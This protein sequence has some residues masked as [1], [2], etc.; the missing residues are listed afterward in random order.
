MPK[1]HCAHSLVLMITAVVSATSPCTG[2]SSELSLADCRSWQAFYDG[3]G[4]AHWT[5]D[6]VPSNARA[7]PCRAGEYYNIECDG[8]HITHVDLLEV[9]VTGALSDAVDALGGMQ[10]LAVLELYGN[11]LNGTIP[12]AIAKFTDLWYLDLERNRLTGTIP[13]ALGRL[14]KLNTTYLACNELSGTVPNLP[15]KQYAG[16][17]VLSSKDF[18]MA[19]GCGPG[20][21]GPMRLACP[22]PVNAADCKWTSGQGGEGLDKCVQS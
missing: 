8:G 10:K 7:D 21:Y 19:R 12:A 18:D 6:E 2:G 22:L 16:D 9:G 11:E 1:M 20:G 15:F 4:G 13:P 5:G 3:H 14:K 17:C